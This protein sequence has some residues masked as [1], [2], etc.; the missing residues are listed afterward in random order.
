MRV[1]LLLLLLI[2]LFVFSVWAKTYS[3]RDSQGQLHYSD[4]LQGLPEECLGKEKEVKPGTADNLNYVPA[5]PQPQGSG[6]E[7]KHSVR[8]VERDLQKEESQKRQLRSRAESLLERYRAAVAGK[9]QAKRS[10]SYRSRDII[11]Q[12]DG[13]IAQARTGKQQLLDELADAGIPEKEKESI[14]TILKGIDAE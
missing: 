5:T 9:R 12:A 4:N 6:I 8:A 1:F 11:K 13:E 14:R 2:N 3:C 7:F 10:W